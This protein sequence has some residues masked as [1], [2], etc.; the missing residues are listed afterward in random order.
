M[1]D[2]MVTFAKSMFPTLPQGVN[3]G[4]TGYKWRTSERYYRVDYVNYQFV[5][6]ITSG[7]VAAFRDAALARSQRDGVATSFSLN[8][9]GGGVQDKDGYYNCTG[10]GQAGKG[11]YYPTCRMTA[12]QVRNWGRALGPSGCMLLMWT[13]DGAY[14]SKS[15]NQQAFRDVAYTLSSKPR[16]SCRRP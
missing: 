8:I 11:P 4:A 1:L 16:R 15:A 10:T 5:H 13:Y 6:W 3:H 2:G 7:N 14:M 9:L 12:D